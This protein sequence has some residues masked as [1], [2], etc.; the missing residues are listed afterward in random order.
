MNSRSNDVDGTANRTRGLL[1]PENIAPPDDSRHL[2]LVAQGSE[3]RPFALEIVLELHRLVVARFVGGAHYPGDVGVGIPIPQYNVFPADLPALHC[4]AC[5][6]D[7]DTR[8]SVAQYVLRD[9]CHVVF[10]ITS[11][12]GLPMPVDQPR[13]L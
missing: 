7:R 5:R 10:L 3:R 12:R 6:Q 8:F 2:G 13:P 11:A 1:A 9:G 4:A